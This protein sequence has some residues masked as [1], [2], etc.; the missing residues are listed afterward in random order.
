MIEDRSNSA[1]EVTRILGDLARED[2][3]GS[4]R[5]LALVYEELRALARARLGRESPGLTL[6][7]TAL[8]HEAYLRLIGEAN[9]RWQN[10]AHFF[11]AAAVAMRRILIERARRRRVPRGGEAS[12]VEVAQPGGGAGVDVI[13]LDEALRRLGEEDARLVEVVQLRYFAGLSVEQTALV[14]GVSERTVK[15]DWEYARAW[16]RSTL[17]AG[18]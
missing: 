14:L 11:S 8:V 17:G 6:E 12:R 15:R 5:L 10:H 9:A 16:L 13:A 1:G 18:G 2:R 3:S 7:P 4:D